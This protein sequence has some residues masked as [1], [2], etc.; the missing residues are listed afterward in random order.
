[1]PLREEILG[2]FL[3]DAAFPVA[4]DSEVEEDFFWVYDDLHCP[5][6]VWRPGAAGCRFRRNDGCLP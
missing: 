6:P 4:W 3:G 2:Q 1:M 5:H